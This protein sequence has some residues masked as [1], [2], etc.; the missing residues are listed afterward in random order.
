MIMDNLVGIFG[1]LI[2]LIF[3]INYFNEPQYS[4]LDDDA[5]Q[6]DEDRVLEPALPRLMTNRYQ[7]NLYLFIFILFTELLFV[8]LANLLPQF[9]YTGK[10]K[11]HDYYT[12]ISALIIIG[13]LPYVPIV[14]NLLKRTKNV[15]HE[16]AKIPNEGRGVYHLIKSGAISYNNI[17]IEN[18]LHDKS[19]EDAKDGKG[20]VIRNDIERSYF[21]A[22]ATTIEGK[23]AK[24]SWLI[25]CLN[26]WERNKVFSGI[27]SHNKLHWHSL[28][29]S[30]ITRRKKI[31]EY[32]SMALSDAD[33]S[34][35]HT[36]LDTLLLRTYRMITCL[37]FLADR[38]SC[39]RYG[40]IKQLGYDID[41]QPI[42]SIRFHQIAFFALN[43]FLGI[44]AGSVFVVFISQVAG[45]YFSSL[46]G[47]VTTET[48]FKCCMYGIPFL[49]IPVIAVLLLK[50][51]YSFTGDRWP[52][53]D[54]KRPYLKTSDRPFDV[55]IFVTILAY[56]TAV[57]TLLSI[58]IFFTKDLEIKNFLVNE[59]T[60]YFFV[61][62][63]VSAVTAFFIAYRLDSLGKHQGNK[64][65]VWSFTLMG[66]CFQGLI[67]DIAIMFAFAYTYNNHSF[68]FGAMSP[69][70][71]GM[72]TMY[73]LMGFSIGFLLFISGHFNDMM[74]ERRRYERSKINKKILFTIDDNVERQGELLDISRSGALIDAFFDCDPQR[75]DISLKI[76]E[77]ASIIAR[78]VEKKKNML[79]LQFMKEFQLQEMVDLLE[80]EAV[81]I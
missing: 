28:K 21:K 74:R 76:K 20:T 56:F 23:W 33:R 26:N 4:F 50:R 9:L 41:V 59:K 48:I 53:V 64:V 30:Y 66:A 68:N 11:S 29:N 61:W 32:R 39:D 12:L 43:C 52:M 58:A 3:S 27:M 25:N 5:E 63:L 1:F 18:I 80:P 40:Y 71:T 16:M 51:H 37:I 54:P 19:Y 67:T 6:N 10:Q 81:R 31:M 42:F 49:I 77:G 73:M 14:K 62:S 70:Y 35:L 15:L 45:Q 69:E 72:F 8:I 60:M 78:I 7:Y 47:I 46:K 13:C 17:D 65:K 75:K 34:K 2:V 22:G 55:Y 79:Y 36:E 57:I 24:I 38:D 44:L